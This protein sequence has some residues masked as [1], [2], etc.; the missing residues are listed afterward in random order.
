MAHRRTRS[1]SCTPSE[2]DR[3][4]ARRREHGIL[5]SLKDPRIWLLVLVYF[6][7]IAANSSLTFFAPTLVKGW[8]HR[9]A[10]IGWIMAAIYLCGAAG[11]IGNGRHSDHARKS[12]CTAGCALLGPSG[13]PGCLVGNFPSSRCR[14][15]RWRSSAR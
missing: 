9:A 15:W 8:V 13:S 10:P 3:G 2:R 12:A 1:A 5:A 7:I 4:G 11:M 14:R 6:C